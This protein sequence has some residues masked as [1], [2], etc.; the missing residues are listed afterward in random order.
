MKFASSP[1]CYSSI[2]IMEVEE[3]EQIH[4]ISELPDDLLKKLTLYQRH[5]NCSSQVG[6]KGMEK[7][8]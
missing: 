4:R 2:P 8:I 1:S 6:I 7:P 3:E 5:G